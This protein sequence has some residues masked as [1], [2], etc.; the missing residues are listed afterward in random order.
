M[1]ETITGIRKST[2]TK[3]FRENGIGQLCYNPAT[4]RLG[5]MFSIAEVD[6]MLTLFKRHT[7]PQARRQ[8][9]LNRAALLWWEFTQRIIRR[10]DT[11][12]EIIAELRQRIWALEHPPDKLQQGYGKTE[13]E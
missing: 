10:I 9:Q 5:L 1:V 3:Y 8:A 6:T 2:L 12:E 13:G 4:K 11:T 7:A